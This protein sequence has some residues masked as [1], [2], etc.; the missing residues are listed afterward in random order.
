MRM[1]VVLAGLRPTRWTFVL[2]P[3]HF[4]L[5]LWSRRLVPCLVAFGSGRGFLL[6]SVTESFASLLPMGLVPGECII[7]VCLMGGGVRWGWCRTS[8]SDGVGAGRTFPMGLVPEYMIRWG[9]CRRTRSDGVGAG[10]QE[11]ECPDGVDAGTE[12]MK[13]QHTKFGV[14]RREA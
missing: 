14:R 6:C 11:Y 2:G 7:G 9:W 1:M 10:I 5:W 8:G 12:F 13:V 3:A 4:L